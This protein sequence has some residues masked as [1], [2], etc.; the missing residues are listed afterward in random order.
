MLIRIVIVA[1]I[2]AIFLFDIFIRADSVSIC[3]L[4]VFP[5]F[6][7]LLDRPGLSFAYAALTGVLSV[8]GSFIQPP[9][10]EA[11]IVFAG[12]RTIAIVTQWLAAA[13][14]KYR[15]HVEAA[16]HAKFEL[17]RQKA[18]QR[19]RFLDILSHEV[20]TPL[21]TIGGQAHRLVKLAPRITPDDLTLRANKIRDAVSRI[22]KTIE[23]IQLA[24]AVGDGRVHVQLGSVDLRSILRSVVQQTCEKSGASQFQMDLENLP[25]RI[26][27]DAIL[28][29]QVFDNLLSNA[30]KFSSGHP[31][32]RLHGTV[33]DG[34]AVV[35]VSDQG[36]GIPAEDLPR[37]GEPYYRGTNSAGIAGTGLGL[38]LVRNF[39]AA[40][41]GAISVD[42]S[43]GRGTTVTV[44][45]PISNDRSE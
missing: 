33:E 37:V 15:Q 29:Q 40:H 1:L 4:Y 14:V 23:R 7:S 22:V 26:D 21:T 45:F 9:S 17:E 12:N 16:L 34:Y 2:A 30:L 35:S 10:D 44:R 42:S 43:P 41:G 38:H 6:L 32:V 8:V 5:V 39:V 27:G 24:S 18:E 28:I 13:L 36:S 19:R 20:N 25:D 3:F 31:V 11:T